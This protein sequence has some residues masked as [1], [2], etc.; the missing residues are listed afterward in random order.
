M[1]ENIIIILLIAVIIY[2][3]YMNSKK[4]EVESFF[5]DNCKYWADIGEC[6]KNPKYM[7]TYCPK[8]C[9]KE[10]IIKEVLDTL[11]ILST[12]ENNLISKRTELLKLLNNDTLNLLT[13][14]DN[15]TE[16]LR[17]LYL[18]FNNVGKM[19]SPYTG[20]MWNTDLEKWSRGPANKSVSE[21]INSL[22]SQ[23]SWLKLLEK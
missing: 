20:M 16:A 9:D 15:N 11:N 19:Y 17:N 13:S 23:H 5:N 18:K 10:V 6:K 8:E 2:F 7:L 3:I 4:N 1:I 14:I 21:I 12:E 22:Y